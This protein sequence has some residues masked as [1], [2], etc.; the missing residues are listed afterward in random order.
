MRMLFRPPFRA[1]RAAGA[2]RRRGATHNPLSKSQERVSIDHGS[3]E[4][5]VGELRIPLRS[6]EGAIFDQG[7][8][9]RRGGRGP[10]RNACVYFTNENGMPS[11]ARRFVA[12]ATAIVL[13]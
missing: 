11:A 1:A 7:S 3:T 9:R 10:F 4:A 2:A 8:L 5:F 6:N 13:R 12:V